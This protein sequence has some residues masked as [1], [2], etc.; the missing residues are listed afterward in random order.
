VKVGNEVLRQTANQYCVGNRP[1]LRLLVFL[2]VS[3]V[4]VPLC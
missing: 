2:A 4:P 1:A 3:E